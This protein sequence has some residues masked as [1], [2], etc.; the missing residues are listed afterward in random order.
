MANVARLD[1]PAPIAA[2]PSFDLRSAIAQPALCRGVDGASLAIIGSWIKSQRQTLG[3]KRVSIIGLA[4]DDDGATLLTGIG[5]RLALQG[6]RVM[7]VDCA[8]QPD[9]PTAPGARP[10]LTELLSGAVSFS[11]VVVLDKES[12]LQL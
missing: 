11:D 3:V 8:L 9:P 1:Q 2:P 4:R 6:T 7:A 10:G 5:R 12:P